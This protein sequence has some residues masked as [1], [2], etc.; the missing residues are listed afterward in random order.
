MPVE[1]TLKVTGVREALVTLR[2]LDPELRKQFEREVQQIAR[3]AVDA[4]ANAYR[5]VPLS[6]MER[7]WS[8]PAVRGRKVFPL[9][10][11]KAR[12]GIKVKFDTRRRS[13]STIYIQ[14]TDPGWAIFETAGRKTDNRLGRALGPLDPGTTRLFGR[15][16][17]SKTRDIERQ[18]TRMAL[19]VVNRI[20]SDLRAA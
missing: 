19:R 1:T 6:G 12:R 16:V 4:A 3:P 18:I 15:V 7:Q 8:G 10:L 14:Q 2:R 13:T 9:T 20:N 11:A 17:Y 5:F